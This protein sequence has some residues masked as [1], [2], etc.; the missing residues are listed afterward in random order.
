LRGSRAASGKIYSTPTPVEAER[1]VKKSC[2]SASKLP[3]R[4]A[5]HDRGGKH[6]H[7]SRGVSSHAALVA[8]QMAS[9]CVRASGVHVD[10]DKQTVTISGHTFKEGD[11]LSD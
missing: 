7:R 8:R 11:Y 6:S 10:Y 5:R 4:F 1:R 3:G 9:L 2:S